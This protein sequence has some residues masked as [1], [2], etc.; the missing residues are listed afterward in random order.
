MDVGSAPTVAL[1]SLA[2]GVG[3]VFADRFEVRALLGE[4]GMGAVYRAYDHEL[5]EEVALKVLRR[6][7][8]GVEGTLDR[9]RREVKLARRVTHP[10]VARTYDLGSHGGTRFLTMELIAGAPISRL[11]GNG[12]RPSLPETLRIV[13]EVARGLAAAHAA[14]VVHR[15]LKPDNIMSAQNDRI[16]ITDFG[17]ARLAEGAHGA[18]EANRTIGAVLGTPAYMAPEQVEGTEVDGRVDIYALGIVLFELLTS[19]L[20][21][22]AETIYALAAARLT[23]PPPDPRTRDA[24]IPEAVARL[25]MDAMARHR[26]HRPDAQTMLQRMDALRG[27]AVAAIDRG[28]RLPSLALDLSRITKSTGPR[29]IAIAP[30]DAP[31]Q[32]VA[33]ANDLTAALGDAMTSLRGVHLLPTAKVRPSIAQHVTDGALDTLSLGRA[34]SVD[35]IID[36]SLRVASSKARLRLRLFDVA[37]GTQTWADRLEGSV[38]D[39]FAL[40]DAVVHLVTDALRARVTHEGRGPIDPKIREPYE[41]ARAAYERFGLPGAREAIAILEEANAKHPEDP[42][43]MSLLGSALVRAWVLLGASDAAMFA[44]AEELSIRA[45]AADATIGETLLTIAYLRA[46]QGELRFA[47]RALQDAL[48]RSPLLSEGH[49]SL[50]RLLAECGH[51]D[52]GM[53]RLDVAARL[54]PRSVINQIERARTFALM[55]DKARAM[56]IVDSVRATTGLGGVVVLEMRLVFWW[57]DREGATRIADGLEAQKTGAAWDQAIPLLRGFG[58]GEPFAGADALFERLL[59]PRIAPRHRCFMHEIAAEYYGAIDRNDKALDLLE[60]AAELPMVDL[61]WL[62]RCPTFESLRGDPRFARVRAIVAQRAAD[63]WG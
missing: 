42:W 51:V 47:V 43:L 3:T 54:D 2:L 17:I 31:E 56:E 21:F 27:G 12:K 63:L 22:H 57:R 10:N 35:M 11:V 36:G 7:I 19:E 45:L 41:R 49:H 46:A 59:S 60:A 40:E 9:F 62:D 26:E 55:G 39:P 25:T 5:Q 18:E 1:P 50:G 8:E 23:T 28:A 61:L 38:D 14:G 32:N 33:L 52:E 13:A 34:L 6:E 30:I 58:S 4:G 53:R 20:P 29:A 48:A 16:V 24:S 15:D 44:R 37:K